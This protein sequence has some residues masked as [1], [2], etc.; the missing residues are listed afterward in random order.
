M[1][2]L[3]ITTITASI[4]IL[5][6]LALS[7]RV[8][9]ARVDTKTGL[10]DGSPGPVGIGKE[11]EAPSLFVRSRSQANFAEYVPLSLILLGLLEHGGAH[12]YLVLGLAAV[13]VLARILHPIGMGKPAPNPY[14]AGGTM[15]QFTYL[16][17]AGL[18]GLWLA[19]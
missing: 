1:P 13:L 7:V 5:L 6:L 3:T 2:T 4:L 11:G 9:Q 16:G 18:A 12:R 10:G 8:V 14:R 17:V 19:L 15:L